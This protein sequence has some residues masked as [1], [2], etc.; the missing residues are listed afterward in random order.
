MLRFLSLLCCSMYVMTALSAADWSGRISWESSVTPVDPSNKDNVD[1][2]EMVSSM[3]PDFSYHCSPDERSIVFTSLS[4]YSKTYTDRIWYSNDADQTFWYVKNRYKEINT[5]DS[6]QWQTAKN[7]DFDRDTQQ[8]VKDFL[9]HK[10]L[11]STDIEK[12]GD[13]EVIAGL[14]TTHYR[15]VKSGFVREHASAELWIHDAITLTRARWQSKVLNEDGT[16]KA[17]LSASPLPLSI[18][19][20]T[21]VIL[22]IVVIENGVNL[23]Y[24]A[25]E[26]QANDA[27][28]PVQE[29][30]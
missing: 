25:T 21:G 20:D 7:A 19:V 1:M 14:P 22:K 12:I 15:V 13:G 9:A 28:H 2:A 26:V 30:K 10:K 16:E 24:T 11:Y 8:N 17:T 23:S 27:R 29:K 5:I 18:P 4:K 3:A 6:G